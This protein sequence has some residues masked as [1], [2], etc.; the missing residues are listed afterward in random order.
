MSKTTP[1]VSTHPSS[2]PAELRSYAIGFML[3]IALTILPFYLVVSD[4]ATGNLRIGLLLA[5]ALAQLV[6]QLRFFI[7]LGHDEKPHWNRLVLLFA[8]LVVFI[9]VVGSLWIMNNLNYHMT[10]HE[11]KDY[12]K[13]EEAIY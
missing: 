4:V 6:V 8:A 7:H 11:V 10:P 3:S 12:I 5:C 1:V 2:Q 9:V 13:H